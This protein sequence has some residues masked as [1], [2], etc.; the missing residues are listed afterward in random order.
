VTRP[1]GGAARRLTRVRNAAPGSP[2]G[3]PADSSDG[4]NLQA[5]GA[6]QWL[7]RGLR[8]LK[9]LLGGTSGRNGRPVMAL[10]FLAL[11][12]A[13]AG[14]IFVL[15]CERNQAVHGEDRAP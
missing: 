3:S 15:K 13:T 4:F 1:T 8:L 5:G 6:D 14:G 12:A 11:L 2:T 9:D 7:R 10:F